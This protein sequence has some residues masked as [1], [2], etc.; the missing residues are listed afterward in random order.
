MS[1]TPTT[2]TLTLDPGL[3]VVVL[4][5]GEDDLGEKFVYTM[6]DEEQPLNRQVIHFGATKFAWP[7]TLYAGTVKLHLDYIHDQDDPED[8]GASLDAELTLPTDVNPHFLTGVYV[9]PVEPPVEPMTAVQNTLKTPSDAKVKA[10]ADERN[11]AIEESI[12]RE[13]E[14]EL[15]EDHSGA[16]ASPGE[17]KDRLSP[18]TKKAAAKTAADKATKK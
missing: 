16:P 14:R 6:D 15:D 1:I 12:R 5:D 9:P 8:V 4:R 7:N 2:L 18:A 17:H 11:E 3:G 10:L 13:T